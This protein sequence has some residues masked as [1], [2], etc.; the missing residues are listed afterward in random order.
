[1]KVYRSMAV[2]L[3]GVYPSERDPWKEFDQ[4]SDCDWDLLRAFDQASDGDWNPP[5]VFDQVFDCD[6]FSFVF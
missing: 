3:L 1:M 6:S 2:L 4:E 5:R